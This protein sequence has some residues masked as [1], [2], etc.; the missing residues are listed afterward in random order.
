MITQNAWNSSSASR[1]HITAISYHHPPLPIVGFEGLHSSLTP[2]EVF[3]QN[4]GG[5][6]IA[7]QHTKRAGVY[8][9]LYC[10][11]SLVFIASLLSVFFL[12]MLVLYFLLL[13][14][15]FLFYKPRNR[16]LNLSQGK[17]NLECKYIFPIGTKRN[18][19]WCQQINLKS[20]ITI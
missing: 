12:S 15:F 8:C 5:N 1:H 13:H 2:F 19:V 10:P 16:L 6:K 18:L 11:C 17:S 7:A 9:S 20:V 3:L 4:S 14:V